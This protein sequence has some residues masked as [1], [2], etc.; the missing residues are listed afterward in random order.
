MLTSEVLSNLTS[1]AESEFL[2]FKEIYT[3]FKAYIHDILCLLNSNSNSDR[4]IIFGVRDGSRE[5]VGIENDPNR[6]KWKENNISD[7]IR[8]RK[9]RSSCKNQK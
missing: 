9:T 5:I 4:Y 6:K 8:D 7:F 1:Q 3:D 2:D